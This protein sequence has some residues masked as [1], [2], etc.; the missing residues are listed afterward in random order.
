[1][2]NAARRSDETLA[3]DGTGATADS[4]TAGTVH[5]LYSPDELKGVPS[6][7]DDSLVVMCCKAKGLPPCKA[8]ERKYL[9]G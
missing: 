9:R 5:R 3:L 7:Y 4:W 2:D 8:F 1:V 6:R